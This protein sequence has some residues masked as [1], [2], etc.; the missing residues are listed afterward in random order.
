MTFITNLL[1]EYIP[2]PIAEGA[3][4]LASVDFGYLLNA[5]M[6]FFSVWLIWNVLTMIIKGVF[7][8]FR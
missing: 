8:G 4:G 2:L 1:G 5:V 6:I 3:P 7:Y